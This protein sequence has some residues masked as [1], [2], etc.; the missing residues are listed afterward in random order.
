MAHDHIALLQ[1]MAGDIDAFIQQAAWILAQVQHQAFELLL[2]Q[3]FQ[4]V[5][6]FLA[7]VFVEL[8]NLYIADPRP[9]EE[10]VRHTETR[11]LIAHNVKY[12]GHIH[13]LPSNQYLNVG[14]TLAPEQVGDIRGGKAVGLLVIHFQDYVARA[15]SSLVSRRC[16]ER[17]DH[18][19]LPVTRLHGHADAGI[20][21]TLILT[22]GLEIARIEEV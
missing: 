16:R 20:M 3:L 7:G 15:N 4:L 1:E 6:K 12:D 17:R 2:A 5:V 18:N 22:Q 13:A 11:N 10:R 14:A 9:Q 19:G 21:A 8:K